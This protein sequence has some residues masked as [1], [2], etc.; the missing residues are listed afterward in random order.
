MFS[1]WKVD[2]MSKVRGWNA[3]DRFLGQQTSYEKEEEMVKLEI[4][5]YFYSSTG[6]IVCIFEQSVSL[7]L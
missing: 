3:W 7:R 6:K 5:H 4:Q 2:S 1:R